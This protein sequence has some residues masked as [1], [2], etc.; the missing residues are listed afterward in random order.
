MLQSFTFTGAG[1][2]IDTK[3]RFFRYE[4]GSAAGAD[5]SIRVYANGNDLGTYLPGDAIRLPIDATRWVI[6]P[7][8][9]AAIGTV[10]L[11]VGSVE[12]ARLVGTVSVIDQNKSSTLALQAF[13]ANA[14]VAAV[15]AQHSRAGIWNPAG[16]GKRAIVEKIYYSTPTA[17]TIYLGWTSTALANTDA[18]VR[19]QQLGAAGALAILRAYD[20]NGTFGLNHVA[21]YVLSAAANQLAPL[22]LKRPIVVKPGYG[23]TL[24]NGTVN[25][26]LNMNM[27]FIEEADV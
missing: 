7:T 27:E 19:N 13:V 26:D 17:Q 1:R 25:T 4:S 16:S 12:S 18:T 6:T 23:L 2:Q 8:S 22:E 24:Y 21:S 9:A 10:R 5:E 20:T 15:A 11:G 3:A 14:G